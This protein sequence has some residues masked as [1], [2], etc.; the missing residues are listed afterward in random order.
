MATAIV[1][2]LSL[3]SHNDDQ[4][5]GRFIRTPLIRDRPETEQRFT[6][7]YTM[8]ELLQHCGTIFI[9]MQYHG[10]EWILGCNGGDNRFQTLEPFSPIMTHI[11][12]SSLFEVGFN[13]N[14]CTFYNK[15]SGCYLSCGKFG[16]N[17]GV[18]ANEKKV[19]YRKDGAPCRE[20]F[21]PSFQPSGS[22]HLKIEADKGWR[23]G[24]IDHKDGKTCL[25]RP[26]SGISEDRAAVLKF[27]IFSA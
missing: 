26:T 9:T 14:R 23:Y 8:D 1:K 22:L 10:S 27:Y 19:G 21:L 16:D 25:H 20:E 11:P 24:L 2:Q 5:I 15:R 7:I 13:R 4:Q 17:D 3:L 18:F 6:Q 12:G